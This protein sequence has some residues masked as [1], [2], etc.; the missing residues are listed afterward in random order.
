L[1]I[2]FLLLANKRSLILILVNK[3]L[4]NINIKVAIVVKVLAILYI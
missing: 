4:S 3:V 2:G 1:L